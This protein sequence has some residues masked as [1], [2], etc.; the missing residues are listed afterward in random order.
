MA[1]NC[2]ATGVSL[3]GVLGHTVVLGALG[4]LGTLISCSL[5]ESGVAVTLVDTK[6]Q[7]VGKLNGIAFMQSDVARM[8]PELRAAISSADCVCVCL[9]EKTTLQVVQSLTAAMRDG[10]LWLDTLSVK[11]GIMRATE[12]AGGRLEVLSLNP[13]FA[14]AMGWVGGAVAA[15]EASPGPKSAFVK[16]LLLSWGAR[17]EVISAE[18]HDRLTAVIQVATHAAVLAFGAT[19]LNLEFDLESVLRLATPPH[20]LL[21]T[22]LHRM[23]TQSAEVYWDIQAYHPLGA[24]VRQEMIN[25]LRDLDKDA[26]WLEPKRLLDTLSQLTTLFEPKSELFSEWAK[27]VFV[28]TG[29]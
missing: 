6:P 5:C 11:T 27:R 7:N 18:E 14:P 22:L 26:S 19:L 24:K 29:K 17:L 23:T 3:P 21:L 28:L 25:A 15:V 10:C 9:P 8:T 13:L 20:R 16:E 4:Q 2:Y 12:M 1:A